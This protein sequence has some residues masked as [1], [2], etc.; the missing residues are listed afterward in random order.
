ML[1]YSY[2]DSDTGI[3]TT[4]SIEYNE[5]EIKKSKK[6]FEELKDKK[7]IISGNFEDTEWILTNEVQKSTLN[8]EFDEILYNKEAKKRNMYSYKQFV[9]SVKSYVV[10]NIQRKT[11][12]TTRTYVHLLKKYVLATNYFNK[13]KSKSELASLEPMQYA[14]GKIQYIEGYVQYVNFEDTEYYSSLLDELLDESLAIQNT[15]SSGC[16]NQRKLSDFQSIML[17]D[18]IIEDFWERANNDSNKELKELYFPL[19]LWWKI[20]NIIPLRLVEFC[21]TPYECIKESDDGKFYIYLRRTILKGNKKGQRSYVSY[22]IDEDYKIYKYVISKEIAD[23]IKE[24]KEITSQN[25]K[26]YDRLIC[27]FTYISNLRS[28]KL[29][30]DSPLL[31]GNFGRNSLINLRDKFLTK[32]VQDEYNYEI[33]DSNKFIEERIVGVEYYEN[34]V[35]VEFKPLK[36]RQISA[37]RL[38]DIRHY[39][40]I[41]LV[42]NDISPILVR[43]LVDHGDINTSFHY[44]GNTSELVKCMSYIKYKEICEKEYNKVGKNKYNV[45]SERIFNQL[46]Y[47]ESIDVD[48]GRCISKYFIAGNLNDCLPTDGECE[49]CDF[50]IQEKAIDKE[51]QK[52]KLKIIESKIDKEAK[53]IADL[54]KSYK[55]TPKINKEIIQNT[56]KL[57][58]SIKTYCDKSVKN[59]G[60]IWED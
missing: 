35:I 42:L 49:N 38:G 59:G 23:L 45:T 1:L 60:I 37:F 13:E 54:L 6:K 24:Y 48:D 19:Y 20:T 29:S 3:K 53:L 12:N 11:L 30:S 17:F 56:L 25:R 33:L 27:Y 22:K 31:D 44:F 52:L 26:D 5:E 28:N 16:N 41:N 51:T 8:F 7:I 32:I 10:L 36:D 46:E 40:M 14:S 15:Y 39:A 55:N 21:V 18:R 47:N 9:N 50:F 4:E 2:Y 34:T 58:N 43:E 57:Q